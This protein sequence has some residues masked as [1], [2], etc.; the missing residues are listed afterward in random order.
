MAV[1]GNL[2]AL[3]LTNSR[4]AWAIAVCAGITFAI[5]QGWRWLEVGV[6]AIAGSVLGAAFGPSPLRQWLRQV[7]PSFFWQRLTDQMYPNRPLGSL[8]KTQW[9]FAWNLTQQRPW[10][11]WGLRNFTPSMR[12]RC[13]LGWV[14]PTIFPDANR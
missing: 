2:V 7:I 5:Y 13:T 14:I 1:I 11:G 8:R 3:I 4:N 10:T 6:A 9:Q 12:R